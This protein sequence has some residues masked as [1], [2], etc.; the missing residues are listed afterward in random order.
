MESGERGTFENL[1]STPALPIEVMTGKIVPYIMIGLIQVFLILLA[2]RFVN[3]RLNQA[4][5]GWTRRR[6]AWIELGKF[7]GSILAGL[8]LSRFAR[9]SKRSTHLPVTAD[10]AR[11]TIKPAQPTSATSTIMAISTE[12]A[13][14]RRARPSGATA[15][16]PTCMAPPSFWPARPAATSPARP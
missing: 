3:P 4:A 1:L 5:R 12:L 8:A 15:S 13:A 6:S 16:W 9:S 2:A 7:G 11:V 10:D 14:T